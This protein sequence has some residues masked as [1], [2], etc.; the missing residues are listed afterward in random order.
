MAVFV[1]KIFL[2]I[3]WVPFLFVGLADALSDAIVDVSADVLHVL[4]G[5]FGNG[6]TV[7]DGDGLDTEVDVDGETLDELIYSCVPLLAIH[8][9]WLLFN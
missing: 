6:F 4:D 1:S 7:G 9:E 5:V 2:L 3:L 8:H